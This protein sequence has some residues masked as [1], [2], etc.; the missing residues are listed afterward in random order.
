MRQLWV[1]GLLGCWGPRLERAQAGQSAQ[2]RGDSP[3]QAVAGQRQLRGRGLPPI[4]G[5]GAAG[6][7][8]ESGQT[9]HACVR[10]LQEE[11]SAG[12]VPEKVLL[13]K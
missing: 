6:C 11:S 13:N 2:L 8:R 9:G 7:G 1:A 4:V 3:G 10:L 5:C 12:M